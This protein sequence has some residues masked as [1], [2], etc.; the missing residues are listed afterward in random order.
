VQ[1]LATWSSMVSFLNSIGV[2]EGDV[3]PSAIVSNE[4]VS[5]ADTASS[6]S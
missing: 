6:Q 2:L 4:Y 3:D 5:T 1:D